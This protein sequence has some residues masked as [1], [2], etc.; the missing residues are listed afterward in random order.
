MRAMFFRIWLLVRQTGLKR[1]GGATF[2]RLFVTGKTD[3]GPYSALYYFLGLPSSDNC[4][5]SNITNSALGLPG[6]PALQN[7]A[8]A[9]KD[10]NKD[11]NPDFMITGDNGTANTSKL[12]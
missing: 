1:E 10:F 2:T 9:C 5:I 4:L 11:G 8:V 7:S 3:N 6:L 12:Y